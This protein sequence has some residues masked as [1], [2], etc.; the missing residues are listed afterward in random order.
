MS[1]LTKA[2]QELVRALVDDE[3]LDY[4]FIHHFDFEQIK[5][6]TFHRLRKAYILAA[7]R[8]QDYIDQ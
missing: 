4:T 7:E 5:D 3:G 8:L 6:E 1:N 2:E